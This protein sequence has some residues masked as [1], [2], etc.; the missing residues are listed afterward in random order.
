MGSATDHPDVVR[1][2]IAKECA[3]GRILGPFVPNT[4]PEVQ[5]SRFGVIPKR[6]SRGWRLILDLSS[7][8][9][10]SVNDGIDPDLCSLSYV[11][12]DDAARAIVESGPGSLLAKIDIKSAYRI[13]C[14]G[15]YV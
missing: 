13:V 8:E 11:T 3:G 10:G 2:H 5:I 1:E 12:I 15:C 4:L 6:S 14:V 7:P 9:G